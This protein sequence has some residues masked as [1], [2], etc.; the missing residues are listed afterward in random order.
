MKKTKNDKDMSSYGILKKKW[1]NSYFKDRNLNNFLRLAQFKIDKNF[2][3]QFFKN[4]NVCDVGCGT[5][6]FLRYIKLNG[7]LYGMEIND[8]AKKK[9]PT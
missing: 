3:N 6:E 1:K 8:Y 5:G 4:G 7:N 2:I 9:L